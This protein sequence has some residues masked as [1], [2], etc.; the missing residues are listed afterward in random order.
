MLISGSLRAQ[1]SLIRVADNFFRVTPYNRPYSKF[2]NDLIKDPK[3]SSKTMIKRTDTSFFSFVG[4][5]K[6]YSPYTNFKAN[7]SEIRLVETEVEIG[8]SISVIDTVFIYQLIGYTYGKQGLDE[9]KKEFNKFHRRFKNDFFTDQQSDILRNEEVIG[10][11]INYFVLTTTTSPLS[12]SW[13]K[14][15][16]YQAVFSILFRFKIRENMA[17]LPIPPDGR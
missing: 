4:E 7:R 10:G 17:I 8:D 5:Y 1:E 11:T 12:I 14:M 9:V 2:L 15:D 13:A 16:E 6:D 3:I